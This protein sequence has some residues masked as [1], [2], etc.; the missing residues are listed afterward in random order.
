MQEISVSVK[1]DAGLKKRF[2]DFC[3]NAG[4][5]VSTVI[6]RLVRQAVNSRIIPREDPFYSDA[7]MARLEKAASDV[8][9]GRAA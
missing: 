5:S 6:S 4:L 1:M 2:D 3:A 8:N 7:N 9:S